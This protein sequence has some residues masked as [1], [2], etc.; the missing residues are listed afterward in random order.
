MTSWPTSVGPLLVWCL[1]REPTTSELCA[2]PLG[3]VPATTRRSNSIWSELACILPSFSLSLSPPRSAHFLGS[4][5]SY[6]E[7][8]GSMMSKLIFFFVVLQ[9]IRMHLHDAQKPL[10]TRDPSFFLCLSFPFD[11]VIPH[12]ARGEK[13]KQ[14]LVLRLRG[15]IRPSPMH[16]RSDHRRA[17]FFYFSFLGQLSTGQYASFLLLREKEKAE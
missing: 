9:R 7:K 1:R 15:I 13:K 16:L 17:S 10:A 12:H 8:P 3:H 6:K 11:G 4:Y 2:T 14:Q 5:G